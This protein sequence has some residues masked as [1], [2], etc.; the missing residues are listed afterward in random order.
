MGPHTP[1]SPSPESRIL[2]AGGECAGGR[3]CSSPR[4]DSAAGGL[5]EGR[6][7][8]AVGGSSTCETHLSRAKQA[9]PAPWGLKLRSQGSATSTAGEQVSR[10]ED[11][12]PPLPSVGS[13]GQ[14]AVCDEHR[15]TAEATCQGRRG[16]PEPGCGHTGPDTP[17]E[18]GSAV[19][20]SGR[21]PAEPAGGQPNH[22][23]EDRENFPTSQTRQP[24]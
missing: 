24:L 11:P 23:G 20:S 12:K 14:W 2:G 5:D 15:A 19:P 22:A 13:T 4:P 10:Q 16:C 17:A 21:L 1:R 6:P 9:S 18:L 3:L 7:E 8:R